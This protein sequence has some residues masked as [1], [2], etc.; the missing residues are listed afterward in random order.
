M[1]TRIDNVA[2]A[3]VPG[4]KT[5][6]GALWLSK[7]AAKLCLSDSGINP[8]AIQL[9]IFTGIYRD[10]HIGEPSIA[11]LI[12]REIKINT[13]LYPLEERTFSFDINAGGCGLLSA[14]QVIDGFFESGKFSSAMLITGD[15]E[16]FRGL[17]ES[18]SF[19]ASSSAMILSYSMDSEGFKT[20][21]TYSYPEFMGSFV[22]GVSWKTK[23][24][25][26]RK[27][28]ILVIE[29]SASYLEQC[30]ECSKKSFNS[31]LLE[32]GLSVKDIDL[33]V[34]SQ[35]PAGF[36]VAFG[37][38]FGLESKTIHI[39]GG[40]RGELHTSGPAFALKSVWDTRRWH[41]SRNIVFIAVGAGIVNAIAWYQK[42]KS[43]G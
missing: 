6:R 8:S 24:G 35:S 27:R 43:M 34:S 15:S 12:Q 29:Q 38:A 21:K 2:V 30:I 4:I 23:R 11:S 5:V 1:G 31:F 17:S 19:R 25:K 9:V 20:I 13:D 42:R 3:P 37:Q 32:S 28:N 10:K 36:P 18:Y 22:S 40:G 39:N 7:K 14:I 16:P 41:E 26:T 33:V